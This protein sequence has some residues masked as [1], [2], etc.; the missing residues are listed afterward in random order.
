MSRTDSKLRH[1]LTCC[2]AISFCFF[3]MLKSEHAAANTF[4]WEELSNTMLLDTCPENGFAGSNYEFAS[5]CKHVT[6]A[7][8][9]AAFDNENDLMY[10]W[11]GGHN[12]Y[13]GNELYVLDL[14]NRQMRRITDPAPTADPASQP[15]QSELFPFD[16]TQPNS[17]H[18][19]D[20]MA[21]L[22]HANKLWAFSGGLAHKQGGSDD[23]T[24]LFDP[25]S[26]SWAIDPATG[27]IPAPVAGVVSAF[28]PVT[29]KVFMHDRQAFY[30][31]EYDASGSVYTRLNAQGTLGLRVSAAIDPV[32]RR[33]LIIGDGQQIIYELDPS[34]GYARIDLP[35]QGDAEIVDAIAPGIAY[36]DKEGKFVAWYGNGKV[37]TFDMDTFS[38]TSTAYKNGPG[39]QISNGTFGRFAYSTQK[40][41]HLVYNRVEHNGFTLK[42]TDIVDTSAPTKPAGLTYIEPYP[43]SLQ[44]NWQASDDNLGVAGY[45]VYV[46]GSV[47]S[48]QL[49]TIYKTMNLPKGQANT[50]RISAYDSAGN[51]SPLSDPLTVTLSNAQAKMNLGDCDKEPQLAGRNDLVFCESWDQQQWWQGK[52]YLSDPIVADPRPL[53]ET[54]LT[55]TEVVSDDCVSGNCL[56][57]NMEQGATRGLS[58]YWPLLE[59]NLAPQNLYFRYYLKLADDWDVRMCNAEGTVMGAG[60][61]F[62]GLADVRTWADPARQCGNGGARGDGINCWSM[63]A[64]YRDC[65]SNDGEACATKPNAATRFG[66]Y[67]YHVGQLGGT[68][69]AG[70]WD[71]DDWAQSN[72]GGQSCETNSRNMYCGKGDGGVLERGLWYRI[73][74][75]VQMNQP[76]REDGIIRGWVNGQLSYEKNNVNFRNE[77]HDF[78]HNRLVWLNIFKGGVHGNCSSSAVYLDQMVLALD[79]PVGG[80]DNSTA[81]PPELALSVDNLEPDAQ[82]PVSVDWMTN[83]ADSCVASGAWEGNKAINGSEQIE[84]EKSGILR[85]DCTGTGGSAAKQL[86]VLVDGKP[87]SGPEI[88]APSPTLT[89]PQ[90]VTQQNLD[91]NGLTLTWDASPEDENVVAYQVYMQGTLIGETP[92]P[93]FVHRTLIHGVTAEYRVASRNADGQLSGQS[94][95]LQVEIPK[96]AGDPENQL[97][98]LPV[99]DTTL[100]STTTR[101]MGANATLGVSGNSNA[102]LKFPVDLLNQGK[103]VLQANLL[104]HSIA[105]YGLADMGI[106][107]VSQ[108]WQEN[109]ATKSYANNQH[110]IFWF[111]ELGDWLDSEDVEQGTVP[112]AQ[113]ELQDDDQPN[114]TAIDIT[115]LLWRWLDE[116]IVNEGLL[117]KLMQ[118]N[119]QVFASKEYENPQWWPRLQVTFATLTRP[120]NLMLDQQLDDQLS[121]SW[122]LPPADETIDHYEV[123]LSDKLIGTT[124]STSFTHGLS[125]FGFT[126]TYYVVAVDAD[127]NKSARSNLLKVHIPWG[128]GNIILSPDADLTLNNSTVRNLGS[129]PGLYVAGSANSLMRFPIELL[130]S[131]IN[132]E[133]ANLVL[134][135][136]AEYGEMEIGIFTPSSEWS[137]STATRD[138]ADI[139][140]GTSWQQRLGDWVDADDRLYGTLVYSSETL[141]D[142]NQPNKSEFDITE[143]VRRWR[144]GDLEN[145][146]IFL[147]RTDGGSQVFASKE[148][149]EK[150]LRPYLEII[151]SN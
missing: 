46:N 80:I 29:K 114:E 129:E 74:M 40:D 54:H 138:Y 20:G 45:R 149:D 57:V 38:W 67:I 27:D 52:G 136:L 123:Y 121:M 104:V 33:M 48:D 22:Q 106:F 61:K 30:S 134:H 24:W 82:T 101:S 34:K 103:D 41:V 120:K 93:S 60:G 122:D 94:E 89:I 66:S 102:L 11:G 100:N 131:S 8:N 26:N 79:Q 96:R 58:A 126:A 72:G 110:G 21:F 36:N 137:E 3:S 130:P 124:T 146:G 9:G 16:G 90:N 112:F 15:P 62:P 56:K 97:T 140:D 2:V 12:D 5:K 32:N 109:A 98:L 73:E 49:A 64:N 28:D 86:T 92:E 50:L 105:E 65:S 42:L 107:A 117:I 84:L 115:P 19:Y 83:N 7:W 18:T 150:Q 148:H 127:G 85:L 71:E 43:D 6:L 17:R 111:N 99:A 91:D 108:A 37:Y 128:E 132:I 69:D 143:L 77:G 118:G 14:T 68:G 125:V 145:V 147:K 78:L 76:G 23:I 88:P 87:I 142:D 95:P 55:F 81:L 1:W 39:R 113:E 141:A 135:S 63:R 13:Y 151:Q 47:V 119:T 51:E 75:Q 70:H 10:I 53:A 133:R 31:Y 139:T 144:S 4:G 59:A 35:P 25:A 44:L 116:E